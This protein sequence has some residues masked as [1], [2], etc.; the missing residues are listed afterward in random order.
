MISAGEFQ[1][2]IPPEMSNAVSPQN[3]GAHS[4]IYSIANLL[5]YGELAFN[6]LLF[7][8]CELQHIL[9]LWLAG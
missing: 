3:M 9:T 2:N 4:P 6:F 5:Y 8:W 1:P 7:T